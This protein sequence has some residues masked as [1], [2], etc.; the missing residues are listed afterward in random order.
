MNPTLTRHARP[1]LRLVA[2]VVMCLGLAACE[3]EVALTPAPT[4]PIE[5]KLIGNWISSDGKDHMRVNRLDDTAYVIGYNRDLYRAHHSDFAGQ[6]F[7][8]VLNLAEDNRKYSILAWKLTDGGERLELSVVSSK[9]VP[10]AAR[11]AAALQKSLQSALR[12][13]ELF[14]V[15]QTYTREK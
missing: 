11:E 5:P 15:T 1:A 14:G 13:P 9:V 8:S 12:H 10:T 7:V 6:P 4:R 2:L 3:Y